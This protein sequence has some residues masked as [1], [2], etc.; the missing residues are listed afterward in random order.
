MI[1]IEYT[2]VQGK[3]SF[4]HIYA[5]AHCRSPGAAAAASA[6][7]HG[8]IRIECVVV[9]GKA[10]TSHIDGATG[11]RSPGAAAESPVAT[12]GGAAGAAASSVRGI[13]GDGVVVERQAAPLQVDAA[14]QA[15]ATGT[16]GFICGGGRTM[17]SH[18]LVVDHGDFRQRD[19]AANDRQAAPLSGQAARDGQAG[20]GRRHAARD[21]KHFDG[22]CAADRHNAFAR[23]VDYFGSIRLRQL[24]RAGQCDRLRRLENGVVEL[25][26]AAGRVGVGVGLADH[27]GQRARVACACCTVARR[28]DGVNRR[29]P[30]EEEPVLQG[31]HKPRLLASR[32]SPERLPSG[33]R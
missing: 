23:T 1:Q 28:I 20:K 10:S 12:A 6:A 4:S 8:L 31:L 21:R 7:T 29:A 11:R 26:L 18:S 2:V 5:P 17:R 30:R 9:Q 24:Q 25:N 19:R 32:R 33:F 14:A 3:A 15:A 13:A 16:T 22:T 27:V